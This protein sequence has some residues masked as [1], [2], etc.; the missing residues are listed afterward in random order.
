[1]QLKDKDQGSYDPGMHRIRYIV[2]DQTS[3]AA[4]DPDFPDCGTTGMKEDNL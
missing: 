2:R 3:P 4:L 1:V